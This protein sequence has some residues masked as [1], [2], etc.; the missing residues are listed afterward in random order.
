MTTDVKQTTE[1]LQHQT[2]DYVRQGQDA[3]V[4]TVQTLSE[5]W[6]DTVRQWAPADLGDTRY[7]NPA[8]L[9][10]QWFDYSEQFL[11]VQREFAH[12]VINAIAPALQAGE[13]AGQAGEDAVQQTA[14]A[15]KKATK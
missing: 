3:F 1:Q 11:A 9:V 4:K 5:T 13:D 14:P 10:D 2:L 6:A 8:E 7:F 12:S 15:A